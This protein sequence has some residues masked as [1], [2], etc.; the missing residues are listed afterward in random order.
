[1]CVTLFLAYPTDRSGVVSYRQFVRLQGWRYGIGIHGT[2]S[3][4]VFVTANAKPSVESPAALQ[5]GS[6]LRTVVRVK[7]NLRKGRIVSRRPYSRQSS[8]CRGKIESAQPPSH[9]TPPRRF[10]VCTDTRSFD[11]TSSMCRPPV[12]R[13]IAKVFTSAM[14]NC[15]VSRTVSWLIENRPQAVPW[16]TATPS[17]PNATA[18]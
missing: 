13:Q 8:H 11:V 9:S 16:Q 7:T 3:L 5:K 12:S 15:K 18:N 1:M 14:A 4:Q 10:E 6:L 2:P 17:S